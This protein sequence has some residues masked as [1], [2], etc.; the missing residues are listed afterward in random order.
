MIRTA[1][2]FITSCLIVAGC[3]GDDSDQ[4]G[5]AM[6]ETQST[7]AGLQAGAEPGQ[8]SQSEA[9]DSES[10]NADPEEPAS[11]DS[12]DDTTS[13][14]TTSD[15][16]TSEDG[17]GELVVKI[18]EP[19]GATP[20]ERTGNTLRAEV[21]GWED[22]EVPI[23]LVIVTPSDRHYPL[24]TFVG[25]NDMAIWTEVF[26]GSEDE[27]GEDFSLVVVSASEDS[28][29]AAEL[30]QLFDERIGTTGLL[31]MPGIEQLASQDVVRSE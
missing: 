4:A 16:S 21:T 15:D 22:R 29:G 31:A 11:P 9:S 1:I 17:T 30:Q 13:D 26:I 12:G 27:A 25:D 6:S 19:D 14:D 7:S 24:R 5:I 10:G 2:V 23:W 3:T 18:I 8:T 28:L 20:V